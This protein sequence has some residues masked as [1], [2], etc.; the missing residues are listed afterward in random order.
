MYFSLHRLDAKTREL[1]LSRTCWNVAGLPMF[2]AAWSPDCTPDEAPLTSTVI[3]VEL[4][5]VLYLL[6]NKESLS[7]LASVIGK[8]VSSAPETERKLNFK[9]T[10]LFVRVDLTKTLPRKIISGYSNGKKSE[11]AVSYP[12]LPLKCDLC[13]KYGHSQDKCMAHLGNSSTRSRSKSPPRNGGK[14]RHRSRQN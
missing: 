8:P 9:V 5:D 6:F 11:I 13:K 4:R 10:K 14:P 12:W 3:P 1:L 7:R 2:V